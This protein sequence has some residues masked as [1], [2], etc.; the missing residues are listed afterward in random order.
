[1]RYFF[2]AVGVALLMG[3]IVPTVYQALDVEG[4]SRMAS[5]TLSTAPTL[6]PEPA[7]ASRTPKP[8]STAATG[9]ALGQQVATRAGCVA[10]HSING[11][12]LIGPTWQGL[13]GH[14]VKITGGTTVTADDAYLKESITTPNAKVVDGF[15]PGIMPQTFGT[16]LTAAEIDGLIAYIHT[17]Q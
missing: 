3:A 7:G 10:C 4:V 17:L 14:S 5:P 15:Q 11:T 12:T 16:S 2:I 6:V 13:A 1:M 9:A 8:A